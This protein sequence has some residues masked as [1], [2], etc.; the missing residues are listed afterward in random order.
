MKTVFVLILASVLAACSTVAG[1]GRDIS[2][3]AEGAKEKIGKAL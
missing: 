1:V 3:G 2:T